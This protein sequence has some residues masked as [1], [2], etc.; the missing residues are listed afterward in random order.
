MS[1]T[2]RTGTIVLNSA[3]FHSFP[4]QLP[5]KLHR[6]LNPAAQI[7]VAF[8]AFGV[9]QDPSLHGPPRDVEL[10][11]VRFLQRLFT[12][13]WAEPHTEG[14]FPDSHEEVSVQKEAD[15]AEHLLLLDV[16]APGQSL[17]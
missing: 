3:M 17:A 15:A 9:N 7:I 13:L 11:D 16:L 6:T 5:D 12:V 10:S 2:F 4:R 1:A 8:D 14:V